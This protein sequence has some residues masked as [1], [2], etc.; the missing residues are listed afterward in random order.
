MKIAVTGSHG[1]VGTALVREL[2]RRHAVTRVG[3]NDFAS[4]AGHDAV[5]HLAGETIAG[6]WTAGKK[7]RIR[8]SRVAGTRALCAAARP[9]VLVCASAIGFYGSRGE[10]ILTEESE[11]GTDFLAEV[12][13]DWEGACVAERVVNLRFGVVLSREGGA[14]ARMWWPFKLG[15]GGII[16]SGRQWWSWVALEDAVTA[17]AL[18]LESEALRGPV[19]V[20][21]PEPVRNVDFT[22]A[23]GKAVRRPVFVPMP[24]FAA[25]LAFGEMAEALLLA[26][27]RVMPGR[28]ASMGFEYGCRRLEDA[29]AAKG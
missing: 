1:L 4:T 12:C 16:G 17:I 3:R 6:R 26:S 13:R 11:G 18:A 25:R 10:E 8:E 9:K 24:A 7:A 20:V 5:V 19:N 15:A 22:R 21:A 27:Q 28:L 29:F 2:E 14:L 23:L